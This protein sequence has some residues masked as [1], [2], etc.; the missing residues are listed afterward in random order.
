MIS[1]TAD[2]EISVA[3]VASRTAS[4][5]SRVDNPRAYISHT[6]RSSTSLL[7]S[8]K[9]INDDRNGSSAPRTCGTATSIAPSAV[10]TRADSY[11]LREP[12]WPS[13]RRS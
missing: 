6:S 9:P 4:S 11:P 1:E 8:R 3:P 2:L 13:P 5:T 12:D 10:R 7:P